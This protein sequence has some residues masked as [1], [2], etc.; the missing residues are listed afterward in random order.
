MHMSKISSDDQ[1]HSVTCDATICRE[2]SKR[3][4]YL[5]F[6]LFMGCYMVPL[7]CNSTQSIKQNYNRQ[8]II[9]LW[10]KWYN[11]PQWRLEG[12]AMKDANNSLKQR[13]GAHQRALI[14][15]LILLVEESTYFI[16]PIT[17]ITILIYVCRDICSQTLKQ[18]LQNCEEIKKK[19]IFSTKC[20]MN[21]C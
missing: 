19:S 13:S 11:R 4:I 2:R 14:F 8:I 17:A 20:I 7:W 9:Y 16:Q 21:I 3:S 15:T 10:L 18:S 12:T 1:W 5:N 6:G